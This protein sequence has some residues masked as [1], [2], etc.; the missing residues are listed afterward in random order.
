VGT[1]VGLNWADYTCPP[2][3]RYHTFKRAFDHFEK[4][5]GKVV[6]ELGTTRSFVH[7][8]LPGC[9]T[10]DV[11]CWKSDQPNRWDWTAG[12]FTRVAAECLHH[13]NPTIH[14]VDIKANH[15]ERCKI[16]TKDFQD[17]IKYHVSSS[18]DFLK[19]YNGPKI[20]LFYLDAGDIPPVAQTGLLQLHEVQTVVE[21]DL[22]AKDGLILIDDVKNKMPKAL[23]E[24]FDWGK[25]IFSIPYLLANGFEM[26][27]DEYQV[28]LKSTLTL[29]IEGV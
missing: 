23:K 9:D 22:L 26:V 5:N 1:Y 13:L 12:C 8:G 16:I 21:R 25:G 7:I 29:L 18:V 3:S 20:D 24:K 14:T 2:K 27:A 6:V 28:I 15:I 17:I 10:D 11:S 4:H 19:T